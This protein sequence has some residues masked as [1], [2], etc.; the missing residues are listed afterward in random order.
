[1]NESPVRSATTPSDDPIANVI[2][3]ASGKGGVGK[4][5][6]SISLAQ[7]LAKLGQR[8]LLFDGD[9]GLANVDVQ[10]G[11]QPG[12]DLGTALERHLPL[13]RAVINYPSGGFDLIAGRSGSGSLASMPINRLQALAQG[14]RA[15][16]E[17][18]GRVVVDL[19]AGIERPVRYLASRA[20]FCL[21]VTTDEP[22]ALTDAYAL[23]KMVT[24]DAQEQHKD[25]PL[26]VVV[27]MAASREIGQRT[28][29][30]L[31]KACERFLKRRIPLLGVI[32]RDPKVRDAISTQ[33]P[34]LVRHPS[35][36]AALD[37]EA[38]ARKVQEVT[39]GELT[40]A[41]RGA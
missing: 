27:N 4:T 21:V 33:T 32:R 24:L 19:G 23:I 41:R 29:E 3:V 25:T 11:I 13:S 14:L 16:G 40:P 36:P 34:L 22:T 1:M 39:G 10:L 15:V 31:S 12:M 28:Y 20:G 35:S 18:Y 2:A 38:L 6:L 17:S 9:L 5:W 7:A 26:G 37:I 30:T 8:V